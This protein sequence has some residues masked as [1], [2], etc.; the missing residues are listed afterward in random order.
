MLVCTE[1][2]ERNR[3]EYTRLLEAAGFYSV[4]FKETGSLVDAILA[5]KG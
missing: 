2:R 3:A 4:N 5:I 1:G